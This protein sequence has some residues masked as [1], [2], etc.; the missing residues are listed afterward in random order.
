MQVDML[1]PLR[2]DG[3]PGDKSLQQQDWLGTVLVTIMEKAERVGASEDDRW[4]ALF[5]KM[6]GVIA[7]HLSSIAK[8]TEGDHGETSPGH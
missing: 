5:D 3:D 6:Y 4:A 7:S 8:V 2:P 1:L